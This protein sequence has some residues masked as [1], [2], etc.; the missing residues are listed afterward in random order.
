MGQCKKK[1]RMV[2]SKQ[3]SKLVNHIGLINLQVTEQAYYKPIM[4]QGYIILEAEDV[5]IVMYTM[6]ITFKD[7]FL[8]DLYVLI[9]NLND[10]TFYITPF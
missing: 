4:K 1:E 7:T 8:R 9:N 6:S 3:I 2:T 5:G 10:C